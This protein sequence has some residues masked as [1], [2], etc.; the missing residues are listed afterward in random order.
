MA[1]VAVMD[2]LP[3]TARSE[4]ST[5]CLPYPIFSPAHHNQYSPCL[6]NLIAFLL[7]KS[8]RLPACPVFPNQPDQIVS[9]LAKSN[10]FP[11]WQIP[12][13]P[14]SHND[15]FPARQIRYFT[16]PARC[17]RFPLGLSN[18]I[19]FLYLPESIFYPGCQIQF[20]PSLPVIFHKPDQV[21]SIFALFDVNAEHRHQI[22]SMTIIGLYTIIYLTRLGESLVSLW[23]RWKPS[24]LQREI[25]TKP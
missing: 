8:N 20:F 11:A 10:F 6:P 19:F 13:S 9:L 12:I 14:A 16:S 23:V 17:N 24:Q 25:Q 7:A 4:H 15:F 5:K 22:L 2:R 21:Y 1:A 3:L 18:P